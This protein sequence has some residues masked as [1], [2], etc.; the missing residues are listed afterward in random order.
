MKR[1]FAI[2][3]LCALFF[4]ASCVH[5]VDNKVSENS[6][7][8]IVKPN[9]EVMLVIVKNRYSG[10]DN[11]YNV[12]AAVIDVE[13]NYHSLP[14]RF[15]FINPDW[16]EQLLAAALT[17]SKRSVEQRDLPTFYQF[18]NDFGSM[19]CNDIRTYEHTV[20]DYGNDYLY[21]MSIDN[22][23]IL[24]YKRLCS[25]GETTQCVDDQTVRDFV[26]WLVVN[27]YWQIASSTFRY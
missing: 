19:S 11:E 12:N 27:H 14:E 18:I 10:C 26:N 24:G 5:T 16:R 2:L 21:V 8:S 15:S 17:E 23:G 4:L 1:L 9:Q 3:T 13:G 22:D 20:W 7:C 25:Y 6:G